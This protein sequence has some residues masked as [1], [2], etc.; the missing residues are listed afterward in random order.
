MLPVISC[1]VLESCSCVS[2]PVNDKEL[3][4][5]FALKYFITPLLVYLL[6]SPSEPIDLKELNILKTYQNW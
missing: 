3:A 1:K 5:R 4:A 2:S 6:L